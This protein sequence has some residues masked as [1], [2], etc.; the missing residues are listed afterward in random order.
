MLLNGNLCDVNDNRTC[1]LVHLFTCS[2]V[3]LFMVGRSTR[4]H[5]TTAPLTPL[6]AV[7]KTRGRQSTSGPTCRIARALRHTDHNKQQRGTVEVVIFCFDISLARWRC[8]TGSGNT[9]WRI[10]AYGYDGDGWC[11]RPDVLPLRRLVAESRR[12]ARHG[13]RRR[14]AHPLV[15]REK[16]KAKKRR[17][18]KK[19]KEVV[20][21]VDGPQG[22]GSGRGPGAYI[23]SLRGEVTG[24]VI[25]R[26]GRIDGRLGGNQW[27]L[28]LRAAAVQSRTLSLLEWVGPGDFKE[29]RRPRCPLQTPTTTHSHYPHPP[30]T[31]PPPPLI[32]SWPTQ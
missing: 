9:I 20:V 22:G 8:G 25:G 30:P 17:E 31:P 27:V 6:T 15:G 11:V 18:K 7:S 3:Y 19:R 16:L 24:G 4:R 12:V 13:S 14:W 26:S 10:S 32:S 28:P 1:S 2:L 29:G 23:R 5:I 21:V